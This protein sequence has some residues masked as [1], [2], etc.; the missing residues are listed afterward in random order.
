MPARARLILAMLGMMLY[1]YGYMQDSFLLQAGGII[2]V[3][4]MFAI[5]MARKLKKQ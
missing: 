5:F 4:S 3:V 1:I 2:L